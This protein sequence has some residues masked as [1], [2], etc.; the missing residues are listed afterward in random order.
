MSLARLIRRP[1]PF[2]KWGWTVR[3]FHL[4]E[5]GRVEFAQWRHPATS[6][7]HIEQA[8]VTALRRWI[9]P[10]DFAIDVGAHTG[11]TSVPLALA[12]GR[13]GRVLA[14]EPNPHVFEV[15]AANAELNRD[16][17]H[18]EARCCAATPRDG[19]FEFLYGDASFCNGGQ[20][21]GRLNPFKKKFP[22]TVEGRNLL[23]LLNAEFSDWLPRL[24]YVK[25]DAEGYD[26]SILESILPILRERR[27]VVRTE[28]FKKLSK[29]D[30]HGLYDLLVDAGYELF[31]YAGSTAPL[32]HSLTRRSMTL[33]RH[34]DVIAVPSASVAMPLQPRAAA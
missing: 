7:T 22:L 20:A 17:T 16:K 5:D 6:V 1:V 30:R 9:S 24:S 28:V 18:I 11:D 33:T 12:A 34:F 3:N 27:P 29:I 21:V 10:G 13:R 31:C 23:G 2:A 26:R 19:K 4:P 14:L 8:E 32:G 15:L 25:V